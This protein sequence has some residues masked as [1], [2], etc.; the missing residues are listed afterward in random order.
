MKK[1]IYCINLYDINDRQQ[2]TKNLYANNIFHWIIIFSGLLYRVMLRNTFYSYLQIKKCSLA[3]SGSGYHYNKWSSQK[4]KGKTFLS[5]FHKKCSQALF[6]LY[7]STLESP[8]IKITDLRVS[9]YCHIMQ[10]YNN[11]TKI[12]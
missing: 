2:F 7:K 5:G 1:K 3:I 4:C 8:L 6:F 9:F 10:L 11:Y 12:Y